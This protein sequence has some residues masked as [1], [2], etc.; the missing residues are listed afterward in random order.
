MALII[1]SIAGQVAKYGFGHDHVYGLVRLTYVDQEQSIPTVFSA[2]LLYT[3]GLLLAIIA[4]LKRRQN[5]P[6]VAKWAILLCGFLWLSF[7][8]AASLHEMLVRPT[9]RLLGEG[10]LGI[11]YFTWVIPGMAIVGFLVLYFLRFVWRLPPKTRSGFVIAGIMFVGGAVGV[12]TLGGWYGGVH[13]MANLTYSMLATIE[14]CLEMGGVI[15]FIH[16]LME[17]IA[18]QYQDV[19]LRFGDVDTGGPSPS[20]P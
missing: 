17:Y 3:A 12:E 1:A 5:D 10:P 13:G 2:L 20:R 4:I 15:T 11:W 16:A 6:E 7:D 14:E 8:E 18:D 9:R 19:Q